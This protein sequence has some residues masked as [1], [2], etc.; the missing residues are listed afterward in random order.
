METRY[1]NT[2]TQLATVDSYPPQAFAASILAFPNPVGDGEML[3]LR[4]SELPTQTLSVSLW[5]VTGR[6]LGQWKWQAFE[7]FLEVDLGALPQGRY[8]LR[9]QGKG[10]EASL[11]IMHD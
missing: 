8:L 11:G 9:L 6:N 4:A 7:Q 5:D 1:Q 2:L 3:H 10:V